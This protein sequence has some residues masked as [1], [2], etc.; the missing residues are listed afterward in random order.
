MKIFEITEY[1]DGGPMDRGTVLC[2]VFENSSE[3]ALIKA[4]KKL[5]NDNILKYPGF[6]RAYP[7]SKL[8]IFPPI[9][10]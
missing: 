5:K 3:L 6:Y 1:S 9:F 7:K 2:Y 10:K 8:P 4:S